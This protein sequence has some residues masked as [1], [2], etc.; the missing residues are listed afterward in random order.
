MANNQRTTVLVADDH[1]LYRSGFGFLLRDRMGFRSVIEAATFDAALDRLAETPNVE[2]ALFDL[3]MPG[4]TG[5]EGLS[6]VKETYPGIRVAIV[7]GSEERKDVVKAVAM[8]L[9]GY[10]PKSLGDD[11]IVGALQDILD[12]RVF[13]PRFMTSGAAAAQSDNPSQ[14][15]R[16]GK[17]DPGGGATYKA[18]SPRQRDVLDCV[19]RGLSNKEIAR[20]LDIAEGTVKIHLAA[21][22]S[23]FGARNRT[24]LATRS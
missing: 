19:R 16:A 15:E 8:G 2:L 7:S 11:E 3:A 18:I 9:N 13:V 24:E 10:V 22:F 14:T 20:E 4:I 6:I 5:P 23:H 17:G 12:G 1:G 21:L